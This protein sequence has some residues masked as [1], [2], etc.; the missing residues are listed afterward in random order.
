MKKSILPNN[1]KIGGDLSYKDKRSSLMISKQDFKGILYA[2]NEQNNEQDFTNLI[3]YSALN[4]ANDIGIDYAKIHLVD[5]TLTRKFQN[6]NKFKKEKWFVNYVSQDNIKSFIETLETKVI[7]VKDNYLEDYFKNIDEYNKLNSD[8][9]INYDIVILSLDSFQ[10]NNQSHYNSLLNLIIHGVNTGV[11]FF[12]KVN[13]VEFEKE[14]AKA[15]SE[16]YQINSKGRNT[17]LKHLRFNLP[18]LFFNSKKYQ[19]INCDSGLSNLLNDFDYSPDISKLTE[20]V[21]Y[22]TRIIEYKNKLNSKTNFIDVP[23]GK[24]GREKYNLEL[25]EGARC[26]HGFIGG[27]TGTGKSNLLNNIIVQI[28]EKYSS[29][30]VRLQ[31]IDLKGSG[32]NEFQI[33]KEHPNVEKLVLTSKPEYALKVIEGFEK[34]IKERSA[35]FKKAGPLVDKI[36]AYRKITDT[37]MPNKL[38]LIDEIQVLFTTDYD[39][40]ERF[41]DLL[42]FIVK[43][44]RFVGMHI[45]FATQSLEDVKIRDSILGQMPL[46]I[47]FRVASTSDCIKIMNK[48]NS[49]P[50]DLEDFEVAYNTGNGRVKKN[51]V[52]KTMEIKKNTIIDRLKN[53]NYKTKLDFCTEIITDEYVFS[54]SKNLVNTTGN[55][56][57]KKN[58]KESI[59]VKTQSNL[60]FTNEGEMNFDE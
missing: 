8:E 11:L 60:T 12:I 54:D 52:F 4:L 43:Q 6:I 50:L 1:I 45:L 58:N 29:D 22:I 57:S 17:F 20:T 7:S 48:D 32:G 59:K 28:A 42:S 37:A 2:Y 30:E 21:T 34:E 18:L 24:K 31:L 19:L 35:I 49:V 3:E 38:L 23:I 10:L 47:S 13:G 53:C 33:Y 16:K 56:E 15:E 46:R 44:G 40:K 36:S 41:N 25:G 5:F 51:K 14:L 39:I 55:K 26:Y 27:Q 9:K